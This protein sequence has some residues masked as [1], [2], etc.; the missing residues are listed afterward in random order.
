M[1]VR[2]GRSGL[3]AKV[4]EFWIGDRD[5]IELIPIPL[6]AAVVEEVT[7]EA[8]DFVSSAIN[9]LFPRPKRSK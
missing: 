5:T 3:Q 9:G 1:K 2:P 8:D 7:E 6:T 4:F